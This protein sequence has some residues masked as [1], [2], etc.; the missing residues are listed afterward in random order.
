MQKKS[1]D[2]II[3]HGARAAHFALSTKTKV[4]IVST[5]HSDKLKYIDKCDHIIA[6]TDIMR[7]KVIES[8]V[9]TKY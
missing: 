6:L 2:A 3:A 9:D 8:C 5:L 4:P 1:L 7:Q